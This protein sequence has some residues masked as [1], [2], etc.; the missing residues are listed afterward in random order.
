VRAVLEVCEL[1]G[2]NGFAERVSGGRFVLV[3]LLFVRLVASG[4]F[5]LGGRSDVLLRLGVFV[6]RYAALDLCEFEPCEE[7]GRFPTGRFAA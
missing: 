4:R 3:R 7:E 6:G 2:V 5:A 1:G